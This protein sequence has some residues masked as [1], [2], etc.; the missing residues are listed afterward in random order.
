MKQYVDLHPPGYHAQR[1]ISPARRFGISRDR[2]GGRMRLLRNAL[3]MLRERLAGRTRVKASLY[4]GGA[5]ILSQ[6]LRFAGV[7]LSTRLIATEQFGL[8]AQASL[9]L[10]FAG[11]IKEI[12]QSQALASYSGKDR[13]YSVFDFQI[14][15][16]LSFIAALAMWVAAHWLPGFPEALRSM[17]PMLSLILV[18]DGLSQTGVLMAQKTFRFRLV[19]G[20]TIAGTI[21][22]LAVIAIFST[23]TEGLTVL[24]LA[25]AAES[26]VRLLVLTPAVIWPYV[27]WVNSPELRTY[28][29]RKFA[30]VLIPQ[31]LLQ[32]VASRIDFMLL[33]ILSGVRE[34][35]IY[36]RMLQ[37]IR[38][39]WS[40]S[41]NLIDQVLTA[42][43]AKEQTD[44][45]A[46]RNTMRKANILLGT[47]AGGAVLAVSLAYCLFLPRIVG[48]D[49]AAVILRHWWFALPYALLYPLGVNLNLFFL[50]TGQPKLLLICTAMQVILDAL[51][52]VWLAGWYGAAG[53]LVA[54]AVTQ[55]LLLS[56][57]IRNVRRRLAG[58]PAAESQ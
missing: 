16:G 26:A 48:A 9:W 3:L 23:R 52:G 7:V 1:R 38:I 21:T 51:F 18:L 31:L 13:R 35:G 4:Y 32:M 56:W 6:V 14:N 28:Y 47:A 54:R 34:L 12:G 43:Y 37:F 19:G 45:P 17:A 39:P 22:W 24:L 36:E 5:S 44:L 42:S 27:G 33:S 11:L 58:G 49:W 29:F 55:T 53:M 50:G 40:L 30:P 20:M 10:S 25:Q 57:Q 15:A 41:I 2:N 46:L 8:F